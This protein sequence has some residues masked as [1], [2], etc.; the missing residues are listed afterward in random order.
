MGVSCVNDLPEK[1][2]QRVL[3]E[4]RQVGRERKG[5][6][7]RTGGASLAFRL[8]EHS[9]EFAWSGLVNGATANP[10]YGLAQFIVTL[11]SDVSDV[12]LV[13]LALELFYSTDGTNWS[14][15]TRQQS[16]SDLMSFTAPEMRWAVNVLP[17]AE[18]GPGESRWFVAIDART[19]TRAAFK[20]QA[21]GIDNVS[22]GV[23]RIA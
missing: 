5:S 3:Q 7:Q 13:D 23:Q 15:Y 6:K 8:S 12:P 11:T 14:R 22:I 19:N 2:I 20:I 4:A 9:S 18:N 1:R 17:G 16:S 21:I 10:T